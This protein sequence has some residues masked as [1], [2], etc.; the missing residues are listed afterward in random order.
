LNF[1]RSEDR[2]HP[3][4][5]PM[6]L[7]ALPFL[8]VLAGLGLSTPASAWDELGHRVVARIAWEHMTPAAR[9]EAI[10]LLRR[11][12]E[13]SGI[14]EL[15]PSDLPELDRD[16]EWFVRTSVW[17]DRLR[18]RERAAGL[19]ATTDWHYVNHF[20]EQ[21]PDGTAVDRPDLPVLGRLVEQLQRIGATLGDGSRPDSARALDLAW[22]L[23]LVGDGHQPMH[24]SAR[25]TAR[26]PEGDRGGNAFEL[27]GMYPGSNLHAYWDALVGPAFPWRPGDRTAADYVGGIAEEL[28]RRHPPRT[29]RPQLLP[30]EFATWSRE[31]A[32]VAQRVAYRGVVRGQR[33]PPAY[34]RAAWAAAEPRLALAGYRL[35]D[36]LNRTLGS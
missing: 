31:G 16:R 26:E 7:R 15:R 24:N 13:W 11:A 6:K 19:P 28:V 22:A 36:L 17:A 2:T 4:E 25:I 10:R 9:A 3:E 30:G 5:L 35:A 32:L 1:E 23:H 29:L 33:P 14:A 27:E 21:R 12:P 34:R 18:A 8:L 20:W